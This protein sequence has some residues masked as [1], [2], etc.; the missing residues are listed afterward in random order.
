MCKH[1]L[2]CL[3]CVLFSVPCKFTK[4]DSV[5]II[6]WRYKVKTH[7][8]IIKIYTKKTATIHLFLINVVRAFVPILCEIFWLL[9]HLKKFPFRSKWHRLRLKNF[10]SA[11]PPPSPL[12]DSFQSHFPIHY[13]REKRILLFGC[14]FFLFRVNKVE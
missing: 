12:F 10:S 9:N 5:S 13:I 2:Q 3:Y 4:R 1:G 7:V 8:H 6:N 11:K 14:A